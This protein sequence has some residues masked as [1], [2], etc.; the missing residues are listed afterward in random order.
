MGYT[1]IRHTLRPA[2]T[3]PYEHMTGRIGGGMH[4]PLMAAI[5]QLV[6]HNHIGLGKTGI[7]D[8]RLHRSK[9]VSKRKLEIC[10]WALDF[11]NQGP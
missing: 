11:H 4:T 3:W 8:V 1:W 9:Q 7:A 5:K 6:P 2:D 10:D